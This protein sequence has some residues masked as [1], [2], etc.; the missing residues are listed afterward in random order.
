[1]NAPPKKDG[2]GYVDRE[3]Q[4]DPIEPSAPAPQSTRPFAHKDSSSEHQVARAQPSSKDAEKDRATGNLA[5]DMVNTA[6]G[7]AQSV[8]AQASELASNIGEQLSATAEA[9]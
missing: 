4:P 8:S 3:F 7:L 9:N 1:M 6:K 5:E 2:R